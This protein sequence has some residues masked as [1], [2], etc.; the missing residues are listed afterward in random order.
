MMRLIACALAAA[1]VLSACGENDLRSL[2]SQGD[3]P[4]EFAV[5][6]ALP[7]EAPENYNDLPQPTPG[8]VNR[9]DQQPL[10]QLAADLGGRATSPNAPIPGSDA[11]LVNHTS[12]FGRDAAIRQT[13][14]EADAAFRD[15]QRRLSGFRLFPEDR[16]AQI[17][18]RQAL[19]PT[20]V[21]DA[22]RSAGVPTP[23]APPASRRR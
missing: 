6:P 20:A 11:A 2:R 18:S 5:V 12:R 19:D 15:R 8:G 14:A 16:Y 9:T 23:S 10:A 21:A 3:G 4:D 17:Y 13:L 22:Y 1:T 7:L